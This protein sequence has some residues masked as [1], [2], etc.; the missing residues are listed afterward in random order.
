[1]EMFC[2]LTEQCQ[3]H[4]YDKDVTIQENWVKGT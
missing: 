3:Y 4:G 2:I 1:M